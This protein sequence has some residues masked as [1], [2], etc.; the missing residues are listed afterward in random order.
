MGLGLGLGLGIGSGSPAPAGGANPNLFLWSEQFQQAAVWI[1]SGATVIANQGLG[2]DGTMTADAL[3]IPVGATLEQVSGTA[4][5]TGATVTQSFP[6]N[7]TLIRRGISGTFDGVLHHYS[8]FLKDNGAGAD[9]V[10]RLRRVGGFIAA[11]LM[12]GQDDE[13]R[14]LAWGGQTGNTY[15]DRL[16]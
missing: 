1:A 5:A 7:G 15:L 14:V 16:R 9:V 8:V 2:D 3:V 12:S 13:V 6:V 10:M 11:A 4:A